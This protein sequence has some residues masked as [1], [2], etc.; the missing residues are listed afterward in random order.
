MTWKC[1]NT[2]KGENKLYS[3]AKGVVP[4]LDLR[5]A[6]GKNLNDYMTGQNLITFSRPVGTNQSPGTY[7]DENGIIQ[8]S[9]ADTPRFDHDPTT[10]ES[11]GLLIEESRTNYTP[12]GTG[13]TVTS[14]NGRTVPSNGTFSSTSVDNPTGSPGSTLFTTDVV[15]GVT[16][17]ISGA[18]DTLGNNGNAM[19]MFI[20]P[21]GI[22]KIFLSTYTTAGNQGA[23]FELTGPG[24][25]VGVVSS[26]PA[27]KCFID[28]YPNGWY[29]LGV[30]SSPTAR[31]GYRCSVW[32]Y[33]GGSNPQFTSVTG[34]G[35]SGFY[36]WGWQNELGGSEFWTSVIPTSGTALTR[37]AD[38]ASITGSNFSSW[39]NQ[40]E[41]AIFAQ[42]SHNVANSPRV[43]SIHDGTTQNELAFI[44]NDATSKSL[45][46]SVA[47]PGTRVDLLT[48]GV[49]SSTHKIS[50]S[51]ALNDLRAALDNVLL[52]S[53]T[54]SAIPTVNA[55]TIG[56]RV[57]GNQPLN[58]TISRLTYFPER[59]P[60][61]TLQTITT[62]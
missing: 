26:L 31:I 35:V 52:P 24:S 27:D 17:Q 57:N 29:R 19:S 54:S 60:D 34:D 7:V 33:D 32:E 46:F 61:S 42:S 1:T 2:P 38:V 62:P 47:V 43:L 45:G 23:Y 55:A 3:D 41:G 10:G 8:L 28:A 37:S 56:A 15:S 44:Y 13:F 49:S 16:I 48:A 36:I 5:F 22:T 53:S 50:A 14:G 6:E 20:K 11:L 18:D 30:R 39:Y 59:L 9:S 58:G 51:Y 21:N 40:T 25:V 4:S 12:D